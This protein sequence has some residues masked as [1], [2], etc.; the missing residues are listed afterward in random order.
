MLII[1]QN[2]QK[3]V[4]IDASTVYETFY[5]A[6]LYLK[7]FFSVYCFALGLKSAIQLGHPSFYKPAKWLQNIWLTINFPLISFKLNY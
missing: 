1:R 7:C 3:E 6:V 2:A 5:I 4:E